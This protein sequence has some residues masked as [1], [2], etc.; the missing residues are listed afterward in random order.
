[1]ILKTK[2]NINMVKTNSRGT[3]I[4][5][6]INLNICVKHKVNDNDGRVLIFLINLNNG[7]SEREQSAIIKP[8]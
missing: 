8:K 4:I 2:C 3:L 5:T 1:M 7:N 6:Y